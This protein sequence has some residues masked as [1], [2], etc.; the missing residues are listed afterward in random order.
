MSG[1]TLVEHV[2]Y[3]LVKGCQS[4][5]HSSMLSESFCGSWNFPPGNEPDH[6]FSASA[7]RALFSTLFSIGPVG[8]QVPF[9][10]YFP[11]VTIGHDQGVR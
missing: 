2:I 10:D 11:A 5:L 8:I 7:L 4:W 3:W 6:A 9:M 1:H